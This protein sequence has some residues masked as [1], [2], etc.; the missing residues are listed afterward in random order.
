MENYIKPKAR[1][2]L[3]KNHFEVQGF[4]DNDA[5]G[6]WYIGDEPKKG[7]Q[8][9]TLRDPCWLDGGLFD[10]DVSRGRFY[11]SEGV[12]V[13]RSRP[14]LPA[15]YVAQINK[16]RKEANRLGEGLKLVINNITNL[17]ENK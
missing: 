12:G 1:E 16:L 17:T 7:E 5:S 8:R 15:D 14:E 4:K 9:I 10:A 11:S 2:E 3:I 6:R 13:L